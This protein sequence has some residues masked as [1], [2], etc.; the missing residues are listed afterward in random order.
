MANKFIKKAAG[1]VSEP[2]GDEGGQES[3]NP[4]QKKPAMKGYKS[5]NAPMKAKKIRNAS[6]SP[7]G[8]RKSGGIAKSDASKS[9]PSGFL[10]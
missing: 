6:F 3:P 9:M 8:I 1:G 5:G 2:D 10:K 4:F 7:K